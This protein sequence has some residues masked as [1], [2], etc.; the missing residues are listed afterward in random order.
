[1]RA[2][3]VASLAV[4]VTAG[5]AAAAPPRAG[6][7]DPGQSL[8]G[9]RLGATQAQVRAAWGTSYGRCR[10]CSSPTW[11]FN[12]RRYRPQGAAVQFRG[13]RV[14]AIV[15]LW[16]PRGWR[17]PSG[18]KIGD[19]SSKISKLYGPLSRTPC[20]EY[21]ALVLP[22]QGGVNVFYVSNRKLWGFGLLNFLVNPCR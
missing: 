6:V 14:E 11:Y 1:M 4:L 12:Y 15:T 18:L 5:A 16:A 10:K 17:T 21:A 7:L 20:G 19:P 22:M 3:L 9:L 8:G 13:G 2:L